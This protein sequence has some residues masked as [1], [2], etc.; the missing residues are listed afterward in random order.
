MPFGELVETVEAAG[1]STKNLLA[2]FK[3]AK[4]F[5]E[6]QAIKVIEDKKGAGDSNPRPPLTNNHI[7]LVIY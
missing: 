4:E 5:G 3:K 6:E 2:L 1:L 7:P